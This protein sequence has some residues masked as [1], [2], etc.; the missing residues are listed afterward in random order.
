MKKAI[1]LLMVVSMLAAMCCFTVPAA[2]ATNYTPTLSGKNTSANALYYDGTAQWVEVVGAI[3]SFTVGESVA[4]PTTKTNPSASVITLDGI[5]SE[6]EWGT[7][8]LNLSSDN[9][10]TI[11]SEVASA[12]NTF[13]HNSVAA[14]EPSN[15][16]SGKGMNY[17]SWY[18][19][20][21]DYLYIAALVT[22][23]DGPLNTVGGESIW[24][25]DSL[26]VRIDWQGPNSVV[27]GGEYDPRINPWP[28]LGCVRETFRETY[29]SMG[30]FGFGY[31]TAGGG[32]SEAYDMALRYDGTLTKMVDTLGNPIIDEETGLQV[33]EIVYESWGMTSIEE[34]TYGTCY[35]TV[36]PVRK[37]TADNRKNTETTYE[38]AIPWAYIDGSCDDGVNEVRG[39]QIAIEAGAEFGISAVLFSGGTGG[40]G[41][42]SYLA[43]GSG[44]TGYQ[45]DRWA[46]TCG[47]SNS[48]ILS[49]VNWNDSSVCTHPSFSAPDCSHGYVC[50]VCGYEYGFAAG[51]KYYF[52][53]TILPTAATAGQVIGTCSVC[54]DTQT[55]AIPATER[56]LI[57]EFGV[58][59]T[60]EELLAGYFSTWFYLMVDENSLPVFDPETGLQR[61]NLIQ[62]NGESVLDWSQGYTYYQC[63][64][65]DDQNYSLQFDY[66]MTG[67]DPTVNST[68][69]SAVAN[70]FGGF[71]GLS[72]YAGFFPT[73]AA[74]APNVGRF[75]IMKTP[76]IN[77]SVPVE[78]RTVVAQSDEVTIPMNEYHRYGFMYD[79]N[80]LTYVITYDGDVVLSAWNPE[81]K[82]KDTSKS[83]WSITRVY[84]M[85]GYCKNMTL[86]SSSY[87]APDAPSTFAVTVDGVEIGQYSAGDTVTLTVP[88]VA[89][90]TIAGGR[91]FCAWTVTAGTVTIASNAFTMPAEP[92]TITSDSIMIGD[93]TSDAKVNSLDLLKLKLRLS[94]KTILPTKAEVAADLNADTKINSLDLLKLKL[95][96]SGKSAQTSL[97]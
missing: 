31:T 94:G 29:G 14:G 88:T 95:V 36:R 77:I 59:G 45:M 56:K 53:D 18:R 63:D 87:L 23:P 74:T 46:D 9:A 16:Y 96:L 26:Q 43:W 10:A 32:Y 5:I 72:F 54:G 8:T 49:D 92:V 34:N 80:A 57:D 33:E 81:F 35:C 6:G 39:R 12:E 65:I 3:G 52:H 22:D 41:F 66:N 75:I 4:L 44:I 42:N 7:P 2:Q 51:H 79:A 27:D 78:D 37:P 47:G 24:D 28:W 13:F 69:Y 67:C 83:A 91:R 25:G 68:Y 55:I 73:D 21:E 62:Y 85:L 38:V 90:G 93:T 1:S 84:N 60:K 76:G 48:L 64:T 40:T 58:N 86:G 82:T 71:D 50:T 19:W 30:N 89:A 97:R 61:S 20:D 11:G 15:Q 70:W 17:Q